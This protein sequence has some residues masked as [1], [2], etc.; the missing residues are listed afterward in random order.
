MA[1]KVKD[2]I[3]RTELILQ[4]ENVRW[5]RLELQNW[6][7]ESY[8]SIVT[9]RP[10]ANFKTE[11]FNCVEGAKQNVLNQFPDSLR[12]LDITRN[13]SPDSDFRAIRIINQRSL[14]N[15]IPNW[16][17][18]ENTNNIQYYIYDIR[19]RNEFYLY[20]KAKDGTKIEL[21]Y[22]SAPEPHNL[23]EEDLNPLVLSDDD[24]IIRLQ[25]NYSPLILNWVLYRCFMKDAD[26]EPNAQRANAF[27]QSYV[28]GMN[29]TVQSDSV[30]SP[31]PEK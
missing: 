15:Q 3:Y 30:V 18:E 20:P 31:K 16:Y 1:T 25:E 29:I 21:T 11:V 22:S 8:L 14:D 12:L 23:T 6:I 10:D 26:Y 4:D 17:Q 27:Y 24:E 5:K 7:N 28:Q 19:K 9:L 2:I 13:L